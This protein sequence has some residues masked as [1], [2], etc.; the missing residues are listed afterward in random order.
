MCI[1]FPH[2]HI[3]QSLYKI[4]DNHLLSLSQAMIFA[5]SFVLQLATNTLYIHEKPSVFSTIRMKS[6]LTSHIITL[7]ESHKYSSRSDTI[8]SNP[9]FAVTT[10]KTK[11][12][13]N[14]AN[15]TF[16][17]TPCLQRHMQQTSRSLSFE[18]PS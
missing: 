18:T 6:H 8:D 16:M 3:R 7:Q 2:H 12:T 4:N 14:Q 9:A 17:Q 10:I 13:N 5:V 1:K 15:L 11:R